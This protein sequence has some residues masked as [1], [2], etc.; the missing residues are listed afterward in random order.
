VRDPACRLHA[1][2]IPPTWLDWCWRP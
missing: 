2:T 1:S